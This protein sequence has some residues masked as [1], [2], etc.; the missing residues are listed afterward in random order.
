MNPLCQCLSLI[1]PTFKPQQDTEKPYSEEE[2]KIIEDVR[3]ECEAQ[4]NESKA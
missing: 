4:S 2:L 3:R 1:D